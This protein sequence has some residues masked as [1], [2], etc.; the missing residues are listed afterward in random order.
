M[1]LSIVVTSP[2]SHHPH[3][4]LLFLT[5]SGFFVE[6]TSCEPSIKIDPSRQGSVV[7]LYL[8][9]SSG[10]SAGNGA[11]S[12][13]TDVQVYLGSFVVLLHFQHSLPLFHS[14]G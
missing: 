7:F 8:S 5:Q 9:Y 2:H 4:V 13:S 6:E 3:P 10:K 11:D 1:V 12:R 14:F